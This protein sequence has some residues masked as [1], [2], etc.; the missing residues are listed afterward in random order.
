MDDLL[1][2]EIE[3]L[4]KILAQQPN[5]RELKE[6]FDLLFSEARSLVIYEEMKQ[7][8]SQR[9]ISQMIEGVSRVD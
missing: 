6:E 3:S 2:R 1:K 4:A 5:A 7:R 8:L 9:R